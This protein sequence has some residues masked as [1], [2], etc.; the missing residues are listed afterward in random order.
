MLCLVLFSW[1]DELGAHRRGLLIAR[2]LV[3]LPLQVEVALVLREAEWQ[4]SRVVFCY[5][6]REKVNVRL[7]VEEISFDLPVYIG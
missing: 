6:G 3:A 7:Q 2:E 5:R 4:N 1:I